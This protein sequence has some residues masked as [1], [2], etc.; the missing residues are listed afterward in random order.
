LPLGD[1]LVDRTRKRGFSP[2]EAAMIRTRATQVIASLDV[3]SQSVH[4]VYTE[5]AA[6]LR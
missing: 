4:T 6:A 1:A 3:Y 2:R 5:E